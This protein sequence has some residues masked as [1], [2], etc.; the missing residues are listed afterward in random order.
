M[1][2]VSGKS[3][4]DSEPRVTLM[5]EPDAQRTVEFLR[6]WISEATARQRERQ[7]R[8]GASAPE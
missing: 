2:V 5:V 6:Q 3:R 1:R 8:D 7:E 4:A